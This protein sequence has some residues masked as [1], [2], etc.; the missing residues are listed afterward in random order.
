MKIDWT[1]FTIVFA[2]SLMISTPFEAFALMLRFSLLVFSFEATATNENTSSENLSIKAKASNG[3]EIIKDAAKTIVKVVQ[4]IFIDDQEIEEFNK[5]FIVGKDAIIQSQEY[6]H[7][8]GWGTLYVVN[9]VLV[10]KTED[11]DVYSL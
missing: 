5:E 3:V 4:S 7:T 2:A 1:T 11:Q 9:N 10:N 8:F 6:S